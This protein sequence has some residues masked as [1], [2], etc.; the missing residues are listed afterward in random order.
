[1]SSQKSQ[2]EKMYAQAL[3][4]ITKDVGSSTEMSGALNQYCTS[5]FGKKKFVGVFAR[6]QIPTKTLQVGQG[7]IVNNQTQAQGGEHWLGLGK[8]QDGQVLLYDSFGR[9]NFLKLP[10]DSTRD[11]ERDVEQ[12]DSET[13]CGNRCAAFLA[14]FFWAGEDFAY[15]I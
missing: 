2:A 13:N 9:K 1:M 11:T 6:D 12:E 15:Y 4:A 3:Q 10:R 7:C 14:V 5:V 8:C